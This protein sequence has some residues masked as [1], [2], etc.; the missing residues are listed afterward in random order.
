[1]TLSGP[2]Q[3]MQHRLGVRVDDFRGSDGRRFWSALSRP[4]IPGPLRA[5]VLPVDRMTSWMP[6]LRRDAVR[7]GGVTPSDLASAYDIRQL[8]DMGIDGAG[9]TVVFW[10]L[11][12]GF[13]QSDFDAFNAKYKLPKATPK[14][15]GPA[16]APS[17][18][19]TIMDIE[20]VHAVA[21]AANLVVYT[22]GAGQDLDD[23]S[24]M[25]IVDRTVSENPGAIISYSW[26]GCE[27]G[28]G[29]QLLQWFESEF[30]KA[31]QLGQSVYVSTGDSGGYE[32]LT[33]RDTA[34]RP[35]AIGASMPA[36]APGVT[37][38]GG[39][40]LSLSKD[41]SWYDEQPWKYATN[42]QGTGGG[43]SQAYPRPSWQRG[44]GVDNRWNA[45][46]M[47]SV[48]DVSAIADPETG[49]SIVSGGQPQQGG[50]TSLSTPIW[51][52]ITALLN[53]YLKQK[54]LK[55][56]GFINPSLYTIAAG[57]P[58]Y[59]AFHD[60]ATGG[61]LAYPATKD[62]DL[63]TGLGTPRVWNLARDLEQYQRN[64]GRV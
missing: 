4:G 46:K 39:T 55:P 33:H 20:A 22:L 23:A 35:A 62:Y 53:Q 58:P 40:R 8:H 34:P 19:E 49:L 48:P 17:E 41:G 50:G 29:Q 60:I 59:P 32:C 13:K 18:G 21:P 9:E 36:A 43:V 3:A 42:T 57:S 14:V 51:A 24:L 31:D 15:I 12:D 28:Q 45:K 27:P 54:G 56:V 5:A 47:R 26:G 6:P 64:G 37:A 52:G 30:T 25:K 16:D 61:N 38:V 63:A 10:E 44:P 11:A 2:A 7:P 1:V